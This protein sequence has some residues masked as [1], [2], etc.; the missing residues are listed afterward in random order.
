MFFSAE[1]IEYNAET[2]VRESQRPRI[3]PE[4][5]R[6]GE[7]LVR[8][9]G[10]PHRGGKPLRCVL[11]RCGETPVRVRTRP[12]VL[13]VAAPFHFEGEWAERA[14]VGVHPAQ[15]LDHQL[16]RAG[17]ELAVDGKS[18]RQAKP[19]WRLTALHFDII[20]RERAIGHDSWFLAA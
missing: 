11:S 14:G 9:A 18:F 7:D 6:E 13:T 20:P 12:G 17:A 16:H 3:L 4:L 5:P 1:D 19:W 15:R 10:V 8:R 2:K